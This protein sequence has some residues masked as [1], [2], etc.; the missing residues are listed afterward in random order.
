GCIEGGNYFSD[1][2]GKDYY[3]GV[4]Q[5]DPGSDGFG[6]A[7]YDLTKWI[8]P[9]VYSTVEDVIQWARYPLMKP[10]P[11]DLHD[12]GITRATTPK[13]IIA[14][15]TSL[16]ITVTMFNYGAF[17]ENF[18]LTIHANTTLLVTYTNITLASKDFTTITFNWNTTGW[19]CGN[20]TITVKITSAPDETDTIDN[21]R[22]YTVTIT[23]PGDYNG[24]GA[25]NYT[26]TEVIRQAWQS[27]E[28]Q[29]YYNPNAD[30]DMDGI[31]NIKDVTIICINWQKHA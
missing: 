12:V 27:R 21:T 25:V 28:D 9:T 29:P 10:Y 19:T 11:W 16:P 15:G 1:Y 6:D 2:I 3:R 22:T 4:N 5:T 31:I 30:F 18:N 26:D 23:I 24:D 17:T 13:T 7:P 8:H 14:N 20:Y